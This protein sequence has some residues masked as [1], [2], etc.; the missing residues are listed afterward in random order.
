MAAK[1]FCIYCCAGYMERARNCGDLWVVCDA[2]G[3][4]VHI[5]EYIGQLVDLLNQAKSAPSS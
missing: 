3:Q 1:W 2:C 4:V 5:D